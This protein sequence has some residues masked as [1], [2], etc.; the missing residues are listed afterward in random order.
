MMKKIVTLT[1]LAAILSGCSNSDV[2]SGDV[3]TA[4]QAKQVQQVSYG[5]VVSV[6]A[7]KI[8]ANA[9]DGKS[10]SVAGSLG[11]AVI[12]G[13]LGNTIGN[14]TGRVLATATGAIGGA[15]LG[16]AIQNKSSQASA[17][18]LEI[19][20]ENGSNIVLVQKGSANDFYAGQPVRLVTNGKQISASPRYNSGVRK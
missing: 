9:S 14:G 10:E 12:G 3:Y 4:D 5:T 1:I 8:Q 6:R 18:E 15:I 20:Q 17:V 2:Y 11:G 13:V 7:V 19:K 16:D